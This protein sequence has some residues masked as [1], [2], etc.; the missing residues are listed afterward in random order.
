MKKFMNKHFMLQSKT[1]QRLYHEYAKDMPIIDYH[2]HLPP[3]EIAIDKNFDNLGQ[4]WLGG[5]HYKWR[6]MRTN[7]VNEKYCTGDASDWEKF[8]KWAE[9]LPYTMRNPLYHWSHLELKNPLGIHS[10]LNKNSAKQIYNEAN[11]KLK[12]KEFSVRNI[13]KKMNVEVICTTDDPVDNLEYHKQIQ[14]EGV[15]TKVYPAWRP[16]KAMAIEEPE[17]YNKYLIKLAEVSDTQ[18]NSY[19]DLIAALEKRHDFFHAQGSRISDHGLETI[20]AAD[21]TESEI[22]SIFKKVLSKKMVSEEEIQ[23]FKSALLYDLAELDNSKNW[24]QQFHVGAM[25][26]NNT[27]MLMQAGPDTGFDSIA[28]CFIA[29]PMSKFFDKLAMKNSLAKTIIYN[30]NPSDNAL[31]ATMIGNFQDGSVPGKMQWGAGWWFLDQ[32]DGITDHLNTLSRLGLLSRFVGMLTDSR[33]YLSFP[34]HEYFRR[35]LCNLIGDDIEKG[36]LPKDMAFLGKLVQDIC[37]FN[38]KNYFNF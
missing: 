2:C 1:A 8:E 18:I 28:D 11:D 9:T 4:V 23:K 15:E 22:E 31:C 5:D 29:K 30:L 17:S 10:I 24:I 25:R 26:N 20:Y 3:S 37:Y 38:A 13:L 16:D 34:R 35:I 6:A 19:K 27:K 32:E 36:K 7:G 33:S 14:A 21:Y 12:S